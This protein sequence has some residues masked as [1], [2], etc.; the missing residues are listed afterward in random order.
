M[1]TINH[2]KRKSCCDRLPTWRELATN[3]TWQVKFVEPKADTLINKHFVQMSVGYAINNH[4]VL[5]TLVWH[6][7]SAEA[8]RGW[9]MKGKYIICY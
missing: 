5:V 9:Y 8:N 2:R 6:E 7:G 4:G 1:E 3:G